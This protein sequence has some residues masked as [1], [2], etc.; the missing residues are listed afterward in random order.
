MAALSRSAKPRSLIRTNRPIQR[1]HC[2]ADNVSW[3]RVKRVFASL[4]WAHLEH[5]Q[6]L[7]VYTS[8][9]ANARAV[10]LWIRQWYISLLA[11]KKLLCYESSKASPTVPCLDSGISRKPNE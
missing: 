8:I 2:L 11:R 3:K 4:R 10:Q 7:P 5:C 1:D 6:G 9:L